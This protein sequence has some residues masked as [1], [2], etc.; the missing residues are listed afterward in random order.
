M[1]IISAFLTGLSQHNALFGF[2]NWFSLVP[3]VF[4]LTKSAKVINGVNINYLKEA[5]VQKLLLE[6]NYKKLNNYL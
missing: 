3:L 5:I 1:I 2:L 6:T 4:V